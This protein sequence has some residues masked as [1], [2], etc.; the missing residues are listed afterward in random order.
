MM[1]SH[2]VLDLVRERHEQMI[3]EARLH[4]F[5]RARRR[6]HLG[7]LVERVRH[8]RSPRRTETAPFGSTRPVAC[9]C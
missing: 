7:A 9:P 1:H 3:E 5:V 2:A 6:V 8:A 4:R